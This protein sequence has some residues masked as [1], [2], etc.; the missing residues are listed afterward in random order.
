MAKRK[1]TPV[2]KTPALVRKGAATIAVGFGLT[3]AACGGLATTGNGGIDAADDGF[4]S[5]GESD[6]VSPQ[7][8]PV[9]LPPP[10]PTPH[11]PIPPPLPPPLPDGGF[12]DALDDVQF[13]PPTPAPHP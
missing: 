2:P 9:P 1:P 3:G 11:P 8:S 7:P 13:L 12:D 5:D 4:S 10:V 6:A